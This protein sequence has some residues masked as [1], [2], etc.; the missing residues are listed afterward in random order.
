MAET[1][2]K[3]LPFELKADD[4]GGFRAVFSTFDVIDHDEDVTRTGAFKD[5]IEVV[6]GSWGHKHSDLPVGKGIIRAGER[7]AAVEGK[8]F[9]DTQ[10]GRDTYQTVKNLGPLG[11]WSYIFR[12]TKQSFGDFEGRQVR[13]IE[14]VDVFSVDPVLRGAG[15]GTRTTAIKSKDEL[16]F[17][18]VGEAILTDVGAYVERVKSRAEFRAGEGRALSAA[19]VSRLSDLA[20]ALESSADELKAL[21]SEADPKQ[22]DELAA[23]YLRYQ[24]NRARLAGVA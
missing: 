1:E 20:T 15:I 4:T 11:E 19:N 16:T 24:H 14:G 10:P 3:S 7:E 21:L 13:F 17:A 12:V 22:S 6:V 23:A 8:F 2:R 5:G 18:E 9:L